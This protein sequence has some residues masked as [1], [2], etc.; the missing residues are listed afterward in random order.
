MDVHRSID[1]AAQPEHVWPLLVE[2]SSVLRW[3]GTLREFR[4]VDDRRGPG[5]HVHVV[6][7]AGGPTIDADFETTEWIPDRSL[8]LHMTSGSGV[9]AYDQR[10]SIEPSA[11]GCRFTLDEHIELPFGPLGRLIGVVAKRS[12]EGH[13]A[14]MLAT[15]KEMAEA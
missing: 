5:A 15:L 6:E 4:Y 12:S 7:K 13:L 14:T 3:Y 11:G 2:P 1:I 8:A 10:W 9:K